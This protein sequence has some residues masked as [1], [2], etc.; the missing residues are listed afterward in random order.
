MQC[1]LFS[2]L[3]LTTDL[4]LFFGREIILDVECLTDLLWRFTF[5]HVGDSLASDVE[6]GFDIE[7]VGSL[8]KC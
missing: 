1:S 8:D 2:P 3:I 7:I 6:Q 4:I 5:D